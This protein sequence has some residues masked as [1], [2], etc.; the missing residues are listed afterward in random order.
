[1]AL[2]G[3][4]SF[5]R[6]TPSRS[7][8]VDSSSHQNQPMVQDSFP[9]LSCSGGVPGA[10][11]SVVNNGQSSAMENVHNKLT[12]RGRY[13]VRLQKQKQTPH[14]DMH[15]N[16][17][18][19]QQH[20]HQNQTQQNRMVQPNYPTTIDFAPSDEEIS[21]I[22][23]PDVFVA[24]SETADIEQQQSDEIFE[25]VYN[26][27]VDEATMS[28]I[29]L[30]PYDK[31]QLMMKHST[32]IATAATTNINEIQRKQ[33]NLGRDQEANNVM[34]QQRGRDSIFRRASPVTTETQ[35]KV[36]TPST[37]VSSGYEM[38]VSS[39][40]P[41]SYE[42]KISE[43]NMQQQQQQL[44]SPNV[45]M[46][47]RHRSLS[48]S[49]TAHQQQQ[50]A[51]VSP[52][53]S[54]FTTT[55]P[56]KA[57]PPIL[58][59]STCTSLHRTAGNQTTSTAQSRSA[60]RHRSMSRTPSHHS[61]HRSRRSRSRSISIRPTKSNA[62]DDTYHNNLFRGAALIRE[63]LIRSMA[64][65]DD[66]AGMD[67]EERAFLE[68]MIARGG[69]VR[70]AVSMQDEKQEENASPSHGSSVR[71]A[72]AYRSGNGQADESTTSESESKKLDN[73]MH[74]FTANSST[75]SP[76]SP[77]S[78][79]VDA[80]SKFKRTSF[81]KDNELEM[82][83]TIDSHLVAV[84]EARVVTPTS[85][86]GINNSNSHMS[87][88]LVSPM[89]TSS[90]SHQDYAGQYFEE[91][92]PKQQPSNIDMDMEAHEQRPQVDEAFT[93]AQR[94]GPLW[95]SLVG[96]HV[97]F[98]S[99]WDKLLP[100]TAP[101]NISHN[102]KWSK[103]YYVARH[104]VK[105]DKRL[106]SR[107]YGVR[108]RRSGGRVLLRIVVREMHTQQ[109]CREIAIG[110]FHPNSK[111]IRKG[112]PMPEA[113]DV[114]EVWMSCRWVMESYEN[115]PPTLDMRPE[116]ND[117]EGVVDRFLCQRKKRPLD[118]NT[119][120]SALGHRKAVNNENVRA[121]STL[122]ALEYLRFAYH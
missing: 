84:E 55:A 94:A 113:E 99:K 98:P 58:R 77:A 32:T 34:Q 49:R 88:Q 74:I 38:A 11:Q 89:Q 36:I 23:V 121:V 59:S 33:S 51:V 82:L 72:P 81:D 42:R 118:Y 45:V 15:K 64:S 22:T 14:D 96:N 39:S 93:H 47:R 66:H 109:V 71:F 63:Q 92:E 69:R 21:K 120:G 29:E 19:N 52:N 25:Q 30:N 18:I 65:T 104:R 67:D 37:A 105:G 50:G 48:R 83:P 57:A 73:L 76:S 110:C 46:D 95:R 53:S 7:Y 80:D 43:M 31:Q 1:M 62:A 97:R 116:R 26:E 28:S 111:G 27:E 85:S 4:T 68:D 115:E 56:A 106:N 107:E 6:T 24:V 79:N 70:E 114:R 20:M 8:S 75:S 13:L 119:M 102:Q 16:S 122:A 108:S 17:N 86:M 3:Y 5:P 41:S 35:P 60:R 12:S 91:D 10:T 103:W 2:G 87:P 44:I 101:T 78:G 54:F 100:P 61:S 9:W 40:G 90:K 112:D 117:Y